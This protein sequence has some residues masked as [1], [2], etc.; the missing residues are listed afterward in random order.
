MDDP[1]GAAQTANRVIRSGGW[2]LDPR[3]ARSANRRRL[4]PG[5]RRVSLGFRLAL[6]ESGR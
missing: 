5:D 2:I 1:P 3:L 6:V 4:V